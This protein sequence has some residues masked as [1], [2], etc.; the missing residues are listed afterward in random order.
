MAPLKENGGFIDPSSEDEE[1]TEPFDPVSESDSETEEEESSYTEGPD[2]LRLYLKEIGASPLLSKEEE[3]EL[4]K[5]ISQGDQEAKQRM[6][7]SNLRLVVNIGKKYIYRGL[8]LPD[9]IEEGNLGLMKAV[10]KF[11]YEKG[12]K[13]STYASWWIRQAIERAI[14]NQSRMIRVP[15][16]ISDSI[17]KYV[18]AVRELLQRFSREPTLEEIAEKMKTSFER[19]R[20]LQQT[21]SRIYSLDTPINNREGGSLKDIIEDSTSQSP[22]QL[23]EELERHELIL[24]WLQLL[25]GNEK[26][27]ISLRF[28]LE[29]GEPKTLEVVGHAFGVT[30]ERVRQIETSAINKLRFLLRKKKVRPE[31]IL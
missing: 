4:A 19:V 15:V 26:R 3:I 2:A 31:I 27:V 16:H 13:F 9:I 30:R 12:Y 1:G 8:P 25:S 7:E 23:T 24:E 5:R 22:A 21:I 14:I 17:N 18:K 29:D 20:D 11:K 10:E 28:G 6:I